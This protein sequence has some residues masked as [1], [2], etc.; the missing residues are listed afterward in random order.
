MK[1]RIVM[2]DWFVEKLRNEKKDEFIPDFIDAVFEETEKAY[3]CVIAN[4]V[5]F[6]TVW[7]PKSVCLSSKEKSSD[8]YF[9][10]TWKEA[11][12]F[13]KFERQFYC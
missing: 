1:K 11:V 2:K 13:V 12:D 3:H 5:K 10:K 9:C 4:S 7:V 8:T 6:Y